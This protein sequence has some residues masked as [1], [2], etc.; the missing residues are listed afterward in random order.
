MMFNGAAD[1]FFW[2]GLTKGVNNTI[3]NL[4]AMLNG[5][6][7]MENPTTK[8]CLEAFEW[9][10]CFGLAVTQDEFNTLTEAPIYAI[11]NDETVIKMKAVIKIQKNYNGNC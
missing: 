11:I 5:K 1:Y 4:P 10:F 2:E 6:F 3:D 9:G 7:Q 8:D